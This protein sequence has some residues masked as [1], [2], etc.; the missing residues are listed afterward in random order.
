[1]NSCPTRCA[2]VIAAN[3]RCAASGGGAGLDE[4]GGALAVVDADEAAADDAAPLD[5]PAALLA[6]AEVDGV[7]SPDR[8]PLHAQSPARANRAAVTLAATV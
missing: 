3:A 1:M 8:V 5:D 7:P 4:L 6:A 2:G